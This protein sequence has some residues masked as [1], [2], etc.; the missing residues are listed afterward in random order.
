[1][2]GQKIGLTSGVQVE[3][4]DSRE[5]FIIAIAITIIILI[6]LCVI[7]V[8]VDVPTRHLLF[9]PLPTVSVFREKEG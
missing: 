6:I 2:R 9:S 3:S 5:L 1:M 7:R 8:S 4:V